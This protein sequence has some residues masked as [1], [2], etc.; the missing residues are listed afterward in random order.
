MESRGEHYV[1]ML[2]CKDGSFYTG[3]TTN[4]AERFIKHQ[5]GKGAKYTRGRTPLVLV[6]QQQYESKRDAMQA[7]YAIK[8]L[9][10]DEKLKFVKEGAV[11]DVATKQLQ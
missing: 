9:T 1:Y 11:I 6:Y 10:R 2:K 4:V 8:Q 7:E 5:Q 3:Y